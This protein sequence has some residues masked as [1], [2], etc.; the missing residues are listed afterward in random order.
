MQ[1]AYTVAKDIDFAAF[2]VIPP[3]R[4]F[5]QPQ[6]HF[7]REKKKLDIE[8]EAID[9][10]PLEQRA[11]AVHSKGFEAALRIEKWQPHP[12]ADEV[13]KNSPAVFATPWLPLAEQFW[14]KRSRSKYHVVV[15]CPN[16]VDDLGKFKNRS[17]K[18]RVG[19]NGDGPV[20]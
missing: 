7:A 11:V 1:R 10:R 14:I 20:L 6:A 17:G 12:P 5:E 4:T 3:H 13:V 15:A 8:T 2:V 16:R 18:I 19:K 9:R